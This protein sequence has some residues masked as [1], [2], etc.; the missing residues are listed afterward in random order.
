MR[1][2]SR[3]RSIITVCQ[4]CIQTPTEAKVYQYYQEKVHSKVDLP[5]LFLICMIF[6][7]TIYFSLMCILCFS[8][9][10]RKLCDAFS[11]SSNRL[12]K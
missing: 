8:A 7:L 10:V 4:S 9:V 12:F 1:F 5:W 11:S 6:E 3:F 2:C